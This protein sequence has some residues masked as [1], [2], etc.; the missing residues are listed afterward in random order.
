MFNFS[1]QQE[2]E[3]LKKDERRNAEMRQLLDRLTREAS[4]AEELKRRE[5]AK[6][7]HLVQMQRTRNLKLIIQDKNLNLFNEKQFESIN[8]ELTLSSNFKHA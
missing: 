4:Q 2:E 3:L 1:V 7:D 8:F 6:V 5:M